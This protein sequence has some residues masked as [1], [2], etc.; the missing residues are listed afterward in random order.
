MLVSAVSY[1]NTWPLVWGFLHGPQKGLFDFRFDLPVHCAEALRDRQ[2]DVGLLPCAELDRLGLDFLP[3]LGIAC[4]GPVRSILLISRRPAADIRT[5]AVDSSSRTSVALARIILAERY[6]CRPVVTPRP[7]VLESMLEDHDAALI[8]GDPALRLDP[9]A[10]PYLTLDLG[11][12]WVAWSGLPMVFAV[13][14]G[15]AEFLTPDAA[16]AFQAS[17]QWGR[18]H[19]EEMIEFASAERGFPKALARAYFTRHIVYSLSARHL[20]GLALF[21]RLV[22]ALDRG[23]DLSMQGSEFLAT[24]KVES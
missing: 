15:R 1:L 14:A 21:R 3:E 7:P 16:A 23:S 18:S 6:G 2:A 19:L 9:E 10:L 12:E 22:V 13:W 5:L 24:S 11:A 20:E 4:E 17:H 8:I